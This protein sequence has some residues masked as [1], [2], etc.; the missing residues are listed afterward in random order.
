MFGIW[1]PFL[2]PPQCVKS[3][4]HNYSLTWM[5]GWH[6]WLMNNHTYKKLW[7][8]IGQPYIMLFIELGPE[9]CKCIWKKIHQIQI[10]ICLFDIILQNKT[11]IDPYILHLK[12]VTYPWLNFTVVGMEILIKERN[13]CHKDHHNQWWKLSHDLPLVYCV[14]YNFH[15]ANVN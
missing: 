9:L 14:K 8:V 3:M 6:W 10:Q 1:W 11:W 7:Y 2:S 12:L 5:L 15:Q 4:V 13:H